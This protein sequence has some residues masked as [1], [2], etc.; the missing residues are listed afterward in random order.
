MEHAVNKVIT[1]A[2]KIRA[3]AEISNRLFFSLFILSPLL[4]S[5]FA[6]FRRNRHAT[7][8]GRSAL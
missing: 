3:K 2:G 5:F 8:F 7:K 4:F 6:V 1:K